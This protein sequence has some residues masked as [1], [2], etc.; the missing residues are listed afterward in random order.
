MRGLAMHQSV[1]SP[2]NISRAWALVRA[3]LLVRAV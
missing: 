1:D 3:Q 2:R